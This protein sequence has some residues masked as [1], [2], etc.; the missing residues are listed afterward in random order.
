MGGNQREVMNRLY[1]AL[2][3]AHLGGEFAILDESLN[4]RPPEALLSLVGETGLDQNMLAVDVGCGRGEHTALLARRH[5]C[6]VLGLD[7]AWGNLQLALANRR[8]E[9]STSYGQANI[10]ALPLPEAS[11]DVVLC[12][13]ML[14]HV[15]DVERGATECGRVLRPGG[16]A[17]VLATV[18]GAQL[19]QEDTASFEPLGIVP[20][21]LVQERLEATFRSASLSIRRAE[22][23]GGERLE[24]WEEEGGYYGREL[25][26]L[27]RLRRD[28]ERY[29]ATLGPERYKLAV[30]LYTFSLYLLTGKLVDVVYW[31]QK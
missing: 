12:Y 20:E 7:L 10:E 5:G 23:I 14:L 6:H 4:P 1:P 22:V 13:D 8:P 17:I 28:P 24:Y 11:A 30:A 26:R 31:L 9:E 27:A 19:D 29:R 18:A 2:L 16:S 25:L 3:D 21:N 15:A